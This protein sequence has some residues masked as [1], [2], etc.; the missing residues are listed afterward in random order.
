MIRSFALLV[1]FVSTLSLAEPLVTLSGGRNVGGIATTDL[2]EGFLGLRYAQPPTGDRRFRPTVT[3]EP[4]WTGTLSAKQ[5]GSLCPQMSTTANGQVFA[6]NEDC[7]FLNVFRPRNRSGVLPVMV[8]IHGGGYT[9][10]ASQGGVI[11]YDGSNLA[12]AGNFVVVTLN[13]RLGN[14][15][16]LSHSALSKRLGI[17]SGNFGLYDQIAALEWVRRNISAFGGNP[18]NVTLFGESAGGRSV[19]YL[20][21]SPKAKGLFER[22]IIQST[23]ANEVPSLAQAE[24]TGATRAAALGCTQTDAVAAA[25]CLLKVSAENFVRDVP[26]SYTPNEYESRMSNV[27]VADGI[28]VLGNSAALARAG[29]VNG[30]SFMIGHNTGDGVLAMFSHDDGAHLNYTADQFRASLVATFG[31][32]KGNQLFLLYHPSKYATVANAILDLHTDFDFGCYARKLARGSRTGSPTKK[33]YRYL[34]DG[35]IFGSL[36]YAVAALLSSEPSPMPIPLPAPYPAFHGTDIPYVFQNIPELYSAISSMA[37]VTI[38]T[39]PRDLVLQKT[40]GG[41]WMNYARSGNPNGNNPVV[42]PEYGND[43]TMPRLTVPVT[44]ESKSHAA[45]CDIYDQLYPY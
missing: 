35:Q 10:G 37:G 9:I 41:Y 18:A 7:L 6:G 16:F 13:Y 31:T 26:M 24:A 33:V 34:F 11:S 36:Q 5:Y 42:W 1:I 43:E 25:N 39:M 21:T 17:P 32:A 15:G 30:S 12:T 38:P 27:G 29:K 3:P 2:A 4:T 23:P 45:A 14:L 22:S 8:W 28:V 44:L 40:M 20:L 19:S